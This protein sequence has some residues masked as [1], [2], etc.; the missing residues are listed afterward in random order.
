MKNSFALLTTAS[1]ILLGASVSADAAST[2][3]IT[4]NGELTDSTCEVTVDGQGADATVTLPTVSINELTSSGQ[5]TGRTAFNLQLSDCVVGT[6]GGQSKVS[7]FFQTGATV[8]QNSG[9][10]LN[11][12]TTGATLVDLQLLDGSNSDSV[13]NVGSTDQVSDMTYVDID[14]T[15]GTATLPYAVEYYANG[16][17]TPGVVASSV[18]YNLQ[19]K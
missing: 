14:Q 5:V 17:T 18:V 16:Q 10:L 1:A 6:S 13:I 7:A 3:T 4:F 2:G 9:R 15:A 12:A 19:Y 11:T 8:D